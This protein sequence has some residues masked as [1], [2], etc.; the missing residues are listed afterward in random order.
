MCIL[1]ST[2]L[3]A[4]CETTADFFKNDFD[5][6]KDQET[7]CHTQMES[8]H[9]S[10]V[11]D[12]YL[13]TGQNDPYRFEKLTSNRPIPDELLAAEKSITFKRDECSRLTLKKAQLADYRQASNYLNY[14][15]ERDRTIQA[16]FRGAYKNVGEYASV[17]FEAFSNLLSQEQSTN[18]VR[19]QEYLRSQE[20]QRQETARDLQNIWG[21]VLSG[22]GNST[23]TSNNMW[24]EQRNGRTYTCFKQLGGNVVCQ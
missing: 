17:R 14:L 10:K 22:M 12:K 3:V 4:G 21:P 8:M 13:V 9:E 6:A 16:L 18:V 5:I 20:I 23:N 24:T 19:Q 7:I 15:R 1:P 2:F 11:L